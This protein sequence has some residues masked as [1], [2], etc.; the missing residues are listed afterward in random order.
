MIP[1]RQKGHVYYRCKPRSCPTTTVRE[2]VLEA[3]ILAELS[4]LELGAKAVEQE[5]DGELPM[6][7][8][9]EKQRSALELQ[10]KDEERRLDRLEDL[11]LDGDLN[12][13][14]FTRKKTEIHLRLSDLR[15]QHGNLPNPTALAAQRDMLAELRKSLVLLYENA[16]RAEKRTIIENVWPNRTVSRKEPMFEPYNWVVRAKNDAALLGGTPERTTARSSQPIRSD[17]ELIDPLLRL[18]EAHREAG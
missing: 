15:E 10:I 5:A 7:T 14:S 1:E 8:S 11:L 2:E 4:Q 3:A 13:K 17:D 9:L 16:N 18:L 12:S 6:L